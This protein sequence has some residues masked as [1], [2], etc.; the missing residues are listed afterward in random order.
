MDNVSRPVLFQPFSTF[1]VNALVTAVQLSAVQDKTSLVESFV[2]SVDA[3]QAN[4]FIGD[5]NVT[6]ASGLEI[7]A[8]AGPVLFQN[9][10]QRQTYD[11]QIPL[12]GIAQTLQCMNNEPFP[13]PF[14]I[15]DLSQIYVIGTAA[16][17]PVRI[18][19]FRAQYI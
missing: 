9:Q 13:I 5:S 3:A 18:A 11:L 12:I 8:G 1:V 7:V 4:V 6:T 14:I 17:T 2:I 19:A 16:S 15:W 10:N